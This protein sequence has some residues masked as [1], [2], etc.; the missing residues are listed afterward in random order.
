MREYCARG[1]IPEAFRTRGGHWRIRLPLSEKTRVVLGRLRGDWWFG[2][3]D[4]EDVEGE[5][6]ADWAESLLLSQL[7]QMD[8]EDFI[9][10]PF[11]PGVNEPS[12]DEC[13]FVAD[14]SN[15]TAEPNKE[16]P[17]VM[18]K[19]M[20]A[21]L[22]RS[23]IYKKVASGASLNPLILIGQ[24]YQFWRKNLRPPTVTEIAQQ[25]RMRRGAYASVVR[26]L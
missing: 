17:D 14:N 20:S 1:V 2:P 22:Y 21:R 3:W 25:M 7:C 13:V 18:K 4:K 23:E 8:E 11:L 15:R 24:V 26:F 16:D 5:I 12:P 19:R 9:A 10:T 6:E